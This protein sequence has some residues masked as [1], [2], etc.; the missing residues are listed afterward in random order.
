MQQKIQ[1]RRIRQ[2]AWN[3]S[4]DPPQIARFTY[5]RTLTFIMRSWRLGIAA[6]TAGLKTNNCCLYVTGQAGDGPGPIKASR[7][8]PAVQTICRPSN[9]YQSAISRSRAMAS[10]DTRMFAQ[11]HNC[12]PEI[13][14]ALKSGNSIATVH[15][16]SQT[17][18][19]SAL[20]KQRM[21]TGIKP[22]TRR[23]SF[24]T[25]CL[26]DRRIKAARLSSLR[27]DAPPRIRQKII[28]GIDGKQVADCVRIALVLTRP[29][30]GTSQGAAHAFGT[31]AKS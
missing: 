1:S 16:V 26:V 6:S 10:R 2:I 30:L 12:V 13:R 4:W 15:V 7:Y 23:G 24:A 5:S 14:L 27:D 11:I 18:H 28:D 21:P 29:R 17:P 22:G 25:L 20:P 9:S 3:D 31:A 19:Q 8:R